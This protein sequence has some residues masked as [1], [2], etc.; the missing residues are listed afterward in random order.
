MDSLQMSIE[1]VDYSARVPVSSRFFFSG[2]NLHASG[3]C[4]EK[5]RDFQELGTPTR[6]AIPRAPREIHRGYSR[7]DSGFSRVRHP[8]EGAEG[9][10]LGTLYRAV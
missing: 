7:V 8:V 6:E 10:E 3:Q 1:S 4:P 9:E 2:S 5:G